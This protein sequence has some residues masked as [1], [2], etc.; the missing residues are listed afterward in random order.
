VL[1]QSRRWV[2]Q[3]NFIQAILV[4]I[5]A[6]FCSSQ[7]GDDDG[8]PSS[9][10]SFLSVV[11]VPAVALLLAPNS[12]DIQVC[13]SFSVNFIAAGIVDDNEDSAESLHLS[14]SSCERGK[15]STKKKR[16]KIG[17]S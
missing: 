14:C 1:F 13:F 9:R 4:F 12:F 3:G 5:R 11:V 17:G 2:H 7:A 6:E 10:P 8:A 15:K 16:K